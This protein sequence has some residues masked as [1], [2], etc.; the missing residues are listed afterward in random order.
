MSTTFFVTCGNLDLNAE[1]Y[2]EALPAAAV[3]EIHIA[4]HSRVMRGSQS[5]VIDDHGSPVAPP[6]WESLLRAL[7]RFGLVPSLVE[8]DN[9]LPPLTQLSTRRGKPSAPPPL[10]WTAMLALH[11][12]QTEFRR[13]ILTVDTDTFCALIAADGLAPKSAWGLPQQYCRLADRGVARN[14]SGSVPA[15]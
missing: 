3:G 11:E 6:V 5:L 8:W 14:I 2:L 10:R 13:A 4:G 1:A 7:K 12:V 9:N 15:G